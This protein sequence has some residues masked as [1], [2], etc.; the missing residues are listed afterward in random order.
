[1]HDGRVGG[2]HMNMEQVTGTAAGN[3]ARDASARVAADES[4]ARLYAPSW[5]D[6]TTRWIRRLPM[7]GWLFYLLLI[8]IFVF[9]ETVPKWLAGT[10]PVGVFV[11]F[12]VVFAAT[13]AFSLAAHRYLI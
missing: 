1:M 5:L 6:Q 7:P 9:V 11:P 12:H 13:F 8:L 10:Y 3:M 2:T 4:S